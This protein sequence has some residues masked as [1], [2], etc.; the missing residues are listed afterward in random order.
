MTMTKE[1]KKTKAGG[2]TL[3]A[4]A[5]KA[6]LNA[7][8]AAVPG[9]S[10]RPILQNVLLSGGVLSGS[11]GEI[12]ID[13]TLENTPP[14]INFL[15]PK[16]RFA[17]ILGSFTGDE[18]T[19]T[20]DA[21]SCVIK[22]GRG[23]WT[24]PT[25]DAGEYPAWNVDGAKPVTRLPVDQFCRAVKGV[26]FAVDDESSRYAL[27][28]VLVEV[29]GEVVTFVATDGRRLSCVNCEHDLAVDDSQTLVPARAMAII[30]RIAAGCGDASVQLEATKN[31]IVATVGNAT[32]T[33]RLLDGRYPRW[34]DTL[35]ERDA[36]ATTVSRADLL[37]AT[38]AAAIC[39]SEESKGVTYAFSADGIWLN[40]KSSEKGE[41]SVTC[42]I[43]DAGDKA[44]VKLDPAFVTEWLNG[45][46]GDADPNV[47]VEAVDAQ[48]AVILR[49]GDNT[50][51]IM[52]LAVDG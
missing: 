1:R 33:A 31:E 43:V 7:V 34:R 26:V 52:P 36:K 45:I 37:A 44:S 13:V 35:P 20:P 28:A 51:V 39:S 40:G 29:K 48:S 47:E 46:A 17:A 38:R 25:E 22:A 32:V 27:G 14:G 42:E 6:A 41:S 4:P 19:I 11:D 15:L 3:S 18:I 2:T 50:G 23:E 24:L 21:T 30:A 10:V 12:R 49:C 9:K 5:L 16:D 8:A